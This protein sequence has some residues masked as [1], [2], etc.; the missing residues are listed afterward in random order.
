MTSSGILNDKLSIPPRA[1]RLRRRV[2]F[3]SLLFA[4]VVVLLGGL[5]F[6][7]TKLYNPVKELR[8]TN[9]N[10]LERIQCDAEG[11]DIAEIAND[12]DFAAADYVL[13]KATYFFLNIDTSAADFHGF[14]LR[15]SDPAASG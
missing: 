4:L 1:R 13:D 7:V 9:Q 2:F 5:V 10:T 6:A 14:T 11:C 8:E 12:W 3:F 15:H